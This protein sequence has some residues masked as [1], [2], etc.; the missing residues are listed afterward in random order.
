[1]SG[2]GLKNPAELPSRLELT[3]DGSLLLLDAPVALVE[4]LAGARGSAETVAAET[5][6]RARIKRT[7]PAVL[8]WR[9]NR[10]GSRAA[11]DDAIKRLDPAGA[12]WIVTAMKKVRGPQTP[13]AH[14]LELSDLVKGFERR[15]MSC[16]KEVR[17]TSWHTAYRFVKR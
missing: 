13:A 8:L 4:L 9:E 7:F 17:V 10:I 6:A 3:G 11:L 12:L 15:G 2:L 5:S 16:D 14:R 1:M